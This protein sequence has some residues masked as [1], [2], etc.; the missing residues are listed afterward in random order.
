MLSEGKHKQTPLA[1]DRHPAHL[2][3]VWRV[4]GCFSIFQPSSGRLIEKHRGRAAQK[5][6]SRGCLAVCSEGGC[7]K[8]KNFEKIF[9]AR[10]RARA[11]CPRASAREFVVYNLI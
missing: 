10:K 8:C 6:E 4:P 9:S 3:R 11:D 7:T 2:S 5:R 1:A